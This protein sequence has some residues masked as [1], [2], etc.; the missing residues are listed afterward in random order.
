VGALVGAG[1]GFAIGF[2]AG[3]IC[4]AVRNLVIAAWLLFAR[5]RAELDATSD[6]LDDI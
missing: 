4:A 1:W 2:A 5:S 3:W 6:L